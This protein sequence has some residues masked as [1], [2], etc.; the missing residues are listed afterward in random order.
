MLLTA[1]ALAAPVTATAASAPAVQAAEAA[2]T[3]AERQVVLAAM[4]IAADTP[5]AEAYRGTPYVWLGRAT[6]WLVI[7][8]AP[9]PGHVLEL[10]WGAKGDTRQA[11]V[12]INGKEATVKAGGWDGFK[13]VRVAVPA[14]VAAEQYEVALQRTASGKAAFLAG[15][16][17]LATGEAAGDAGAKPKTMSLE[18]GP[19]AA[20][21][22]PPAA[23]AEMRPLWDTPTPPMSPCADAEREAAFRRAEA[24][25]RRWA[26]ALYRCRRFV[27][28]WLGHADPGTGLIPRN[29]SRDTAI[30]NAKD[31]AADNYPFMVL[32][33]ALTDRAM[34]D[35]R[36]REM[37][38][39]ER[40]VTSRLGPLPDT[41]AFSKQGFA[42][43]KIDLADILFG[44]SEYVKD[45]LLP[46][47][48][49]LGPSPWCDRML[50]ILDA[51]GERAPVESPH[52]NIV[53]T[54]VEV[55][56]EMLQTLSRIHFMTGDAKYLDWAVR[57]GDYY[58]LGDHH[59]TRDMTSL[60]LDDHGC[61]LVS[62]LTELYAACHFVRPEKARAY[63]QGVHAMLDR[64][65][66]IGTNADGFMYT[67]IDPK[68]G[69]VV[70]QALSDNWG[71]N[72]NGFYTVYL[73]D[74]VERYR[75]AVVKA[76][77]SLAKPEYLRYPWEGWG[78]DGIADCVEGALNLTNRE[79][80]EGVD[81]WIDANIARMFGIQKADGVVEGWHGD[82][83]FARTA[84]LFA[85]WKS[86]GCAVR[87][88]RKDLRVGAVRQGEALLVSLTAEEAWEG[89]LLFDVPRHRV[90]MKLPMDWPRINQF[91]E[92][93][94]VE[95]E[96]SYTV[97]DLAAGAAATHT[98]RA[99]AEGVPIRLEP[100]REVRLEV[101]KDNDK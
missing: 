30:W 67:T 53:S 3:P 16:R 12:V 75:Q 65:L 69:K 49:W 8:V 47:T 15:V 63:R 86:E 29:L 64:V 100:G 1:A 43:E 44:S 6:L 37:L 90:H 79:P 98:G 80:V 91:P 94:T 18:V 17:L 68:G 51:M 93:F 34:F 48:E 45:G 62:G 22:P 83:N 88:W 84:I 57:L 42:T 101:E 35:G 76:L 85:L 77:G 50:E 24:N 56:G 52:G 41:Y 71:Y 21:P 14:G 97:R 11:V 92:W 31:A 36:M 54:S 78:S 9:A 99:M 20:V 89:R 66:A 72:Y 5:E 95:A 70:Q 81:A 13:P 10:D 26:E 40:R 2:G 4:A 58:L 60:R 46:L 55:N 32:T 25:A 33:C 87:P 27:D 59:P 61:E 73:V 96:A 74:G 23:F 28:G 82:G 19:A 39:T 7:P 38:A